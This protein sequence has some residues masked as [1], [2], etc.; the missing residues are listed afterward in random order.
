MLRSFASRLAH[1]SD[2]FFHPAPGEAV[3]GPSPDNISERIATGT[4]TAIGISDEPSV[5]LT[6]LIFLV[7]FY[8]T[9][10]YHTNKNCGIFGPATNIRIK[11]LISKDPGVGPLL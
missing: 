2:N 6:D 8:A 11:N 9:Y 5:S 10:L 1:L 4:D 3:I 7:L